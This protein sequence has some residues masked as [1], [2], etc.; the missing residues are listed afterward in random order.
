MN[1]FNMVSRYNSGNGIPTQNF[2]TNFGF[3]PNLI[4]PEFSN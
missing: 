1:P 3:L 2:Y 4:H